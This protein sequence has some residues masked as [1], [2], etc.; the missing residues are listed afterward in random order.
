MLSDKVKGVSELACLVQG[1][2]Q[3]V[4][5]ALCFH[6]GSRKVLMSPGHWERLC[7]LSFSEGV[8]VV[9]TLLALNSLNEVSLT[10]V[11]SQATQR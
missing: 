5:G 10:A 9:R 11:W 8:A 2:R 4:G 1:G 6:R 7:H 3:R